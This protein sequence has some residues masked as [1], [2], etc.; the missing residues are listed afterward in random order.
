[1]E[2]AVFPARKCRETIWSALGIAHSCELVDQHPGPHATFSI[3]ST[4]EARDRYESDH[5]EWRKHI[6]T[7]FFA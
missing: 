2:S 5:P 1:M 6:N 3:D 7:D 4:V